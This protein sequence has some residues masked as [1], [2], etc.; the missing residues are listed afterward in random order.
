MS[1]LIGVLVDMLL[2]IS[3]GML[4]GCLRVRVL[5]GLLA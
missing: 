4:I 3:V 1:V 2:K 5:I